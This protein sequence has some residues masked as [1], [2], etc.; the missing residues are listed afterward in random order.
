MVGLK[1]LFIFACHLDR[2]FLDV[3]SLGL[4]VIIRQDNVIFTTKLGATVLALVD[5][6]VD[7]LLLRCK[8][9]ATP[10]NVRS[11]NNVN[12]SKHWFLFAIHNSEGIS[13]ATTQ[14]PSH[15]ELILLQP[16]IYDNSEN[17][18]IHDMPTQ[19]CKCR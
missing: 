1:K 9:L 17:H 8:I 10:P 19:T 14:K 11:L 16:K 12:I 6:C 4:N 18:S 3:D 13:L 15:Y 7:A 5:Q 2:F